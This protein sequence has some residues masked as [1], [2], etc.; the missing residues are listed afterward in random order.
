M[1]KIIFLTFLTFIYCTSLMSSQSNSDSIETKYEKQFQKLIGLHKKIGNKFTVLEKLQPVAIAENDNFYI[2][3]VDENSNYKFLKKAPIS[4]PIPKGIRAAMPVEAYNYKVI[5]VVTGDVFEK[6]E[7]MLVLFHEFV[8]C[9]QFQ[10]VEMK[11]KEKLEINM[12]AMKNQ[13]FMWEINYAFP[14]T[15]EK[16]EKAYSDFLLALQTKD[17]IEIRNSRKILGE[18]LSKKDFEYLTWQ[19]WKEGYARYIENKLR[20]LFDVKVNDYGKEKPYNRITFYY[21]GSKYIEYLIDKNPQLENNLELIFNNI[22][23]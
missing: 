6:D 16:F 18:L 15:N 5:C 3:E 8:H 1:K 13:D 9:V 21:G 20:M 22:T 4:F 23:N 17:S 14:Y 7:D 2:F 11:L 19:E 12:E 10:T